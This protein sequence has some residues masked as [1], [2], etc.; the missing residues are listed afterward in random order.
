MTKAEKAAA[1]N[2]VIQGSRGEFARSKSAEAYVREDGKLR[3]RANMVGYV[4]KM[5]FAQLLGLLHGHDIQAL[6]AAFS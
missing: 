3:Y 4:Q 5:T 2:A 1:I 6:K